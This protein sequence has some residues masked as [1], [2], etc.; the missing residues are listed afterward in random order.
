MNLFKR[1]KQP[2]MTDIMQQLAKQNHIKASNITVKT[3]PFGPIIY[4]R[5]NKIKW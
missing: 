5:R 2:P 3:T 1:K 4:Y